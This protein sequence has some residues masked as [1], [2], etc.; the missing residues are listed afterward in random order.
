MQGKLTFVYQKSGDVCLIFCKNANLSK[1]SL[2]VEKQLVL[3]NSAANIFEQEQLRVFVN[4]FFGIFVFVF[5]I[6]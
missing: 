4:G 2:S 6:K 3:M 1:P 5:L